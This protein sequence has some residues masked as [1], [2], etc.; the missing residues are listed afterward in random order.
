LEREVLK[1]ADLFRLETLLQHCVEAFGRGLTVDTAVEALVW[2]HL[3]GPA[4]AR[5]VATEFF[6]RNG[7][8]IEV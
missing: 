2:A 5:K 6:V 3:F 4:E 8:R 7:R 1:A